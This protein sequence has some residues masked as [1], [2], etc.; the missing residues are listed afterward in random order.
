MGKITKLLILT[1]IFS[2]QLDT[3][4]ANEGH[5]E[6]AGPEDK[7][8]PVSPMED[9]LNKY[10]AEGSPE[11]AAEERST[12]MSEADLVVHFF[13]QGPTGKGAFPEFQVL[14]GKKCSISSD[15]EFAARW[16]RNDQ[17]QLQLKDTTLM[18]GPSYGFKNRTHKGKHRRYNIPQPLI[19][20]YSPFGLE[21]GKYSRSFAGKEFQDL[22][23]SGQLQIETLL[24]ESDD[25]SLKFKVTEP[26]RTPYVQ[27]ANL[28]S[29]AYLRTRVGTASLMPY[30]VKFTPKNTPLS[31]D[32]DFLTSKR[33]QVQ[34]DSGTAIH[35]ADKGHIACRP[36]NNA[37]S[38]GC[39]RVTSSFAK[40]TFDAFSEYIT[41]AGG[42]VSDSGSFHIPERSV[43]DENGK[44]VADKLI[45]SPQH[46][47][48]LKAMLKL[49][50]STS[51]KG[52]V[53]DSPNSMIDHYNS[54]RV[55]AW[56]EVVASHKKGEL[57]NEVS[58]HVR[59]ILASGSKIEKLQTSQN[60]ALEKYNKHKDGKSKR[61]QKKAAEAAQKYNA[62]K[63]EIS[64]IAA[65][66]SLHQAK[67]RDHV[68]HVAKSPNT[69]FNDL[70]P[71]VQKSYLINQQAERYK[72]VGMKDP[73]KADKP[74][75]ELDAEE[76]AI[77][78]D[79]KVD[80]YNSLADALE[81]YYGIQY[82]EDVPKKC[83]DQISRYR[84][85]RKPARA[86]PVNEDD[87]IPRAIPLDD[88]AGIP[89][90]LPVN[91]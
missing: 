43:R 31:T 40:R 72:A 14:S 24:E 60:E 79:N 89:R 6:S 28:N 82:G 83:Q 21:A 45:D 4:I 63:A 58:T 75:L 53:P 3:A 67:F 15:M 29:S 20:E 16:E 26:G 32:T 51:I 47:K 2:W 77:Y 17:G 88:N 9:Y 34:N 84:Q 56:N 78:D 73:S 39:S 76:A 50:R 59:N 23:R 52:F 86:L 90:A 11:R 71:S 55:E 18:V 13:Q 54:M 5:S 62:D 1:A 65:T 12:P 19:G 91:D 61:K 64:R 10:F 44:H 41:D 80:L 81:S 33:W 49:R 46:L 38:A 85:Y 35:G 68:K 7:E 70:H 74:M 87:F 66:R 42:Q 30:S 69:L 36:D 48:N 8:Q 57:S 27:R 37:G 25:K 22:T